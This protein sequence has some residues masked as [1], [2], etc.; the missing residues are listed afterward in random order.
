M[1]AAVKCVAD[2]S[3]KLAVPDGERCGGVAR[4]E[5]LNA[6]SG[7]RLPAACHDVDERAPP[8]TEF[9]CCGRTGTLPCGPAT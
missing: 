9:L 2:K 1:C 3:L 7:A 8:A 4:R 6:G 5:M